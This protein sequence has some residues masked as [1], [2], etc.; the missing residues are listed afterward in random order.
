MPGKHVHAASRDLTKQ[1][2]QKHVFSQRSAKLNIII[3]RQH[4]IW[5]I[6]SPAS[7]HAEAS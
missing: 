6:F 2:A 4:G 1:N 7:L 5:S 3:R